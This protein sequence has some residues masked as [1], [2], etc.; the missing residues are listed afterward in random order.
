MEFFE[1]VLVFSMT[2]LL[3]LTILKTVLDYKKAQLKSKNQEGEQAG[4]TVGELK[5]VL[6]DVVREANEPL[7]ERIEELERE[8]DGLP[9]P[10][11]RDL[12]AGVDEGPVGA[13]ELELDEEASDKT[14]GRR[15]RG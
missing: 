13:E 4:F 10:R 6:A 8:R 2:V 14:L 9:A 12:F 7:V 3:P 1:F 5:K 15:V 11:S